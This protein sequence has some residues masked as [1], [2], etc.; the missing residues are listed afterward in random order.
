MANNQ[1]TQYGGAAN[2]GSSPPPAG[3]P[4]QSTKN[5][6]VVAG[7]AHLSSLF[8]PVFVPL[9][10][11]LVVRD[12]MPFA[13]RQ[14]KQAFFFHL[15]MSVFALVV[16]SA[17][18]FSYIST[19]FA[20]VSQAITSDVPTSTTMPAWFFALST[21]VIILILSGYALCIYG[22]VQAFQGKDFSYPLLGR[23]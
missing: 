13:S 14:A 23:L 8:A 16:A 18:F 7:I 11:W 9:I 19:I 3:S 22:A 15:L 2:P 6:T 1:H 12:T 10:I 4:A 5:E 17:L 20:T 21:F